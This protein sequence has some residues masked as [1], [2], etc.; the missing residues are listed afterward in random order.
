MIMHPKAYATRFSSLHTVEQSL[1]GK[2]NY[3]NAGEHPFFL[4]V[5]QGDQN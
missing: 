2:T 3:A 5:I 1:G 4:P